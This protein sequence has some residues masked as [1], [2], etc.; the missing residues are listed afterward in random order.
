MFKYKFLTLHEA[1]KGTGAG[2]NAGGEQAGTHE[3]DKEKQT[4]P[5]GAEKTFT[6]AELEA[7]IKDRLDR[8]KRKAEEKADQARKDAERKA[9]EEQGEYKKMYEAL[10][11]DLR[12]KERQVLEVKKHTLLLKAGYTEE[13]AERYVKYLTADSEEGLATDLETLKADIPPTA[14]GVDPSTQGNGQRR[15]HKENSPYDY[16]KSVLERLKKSGRLR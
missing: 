3:A 1:D 14:K 12:E 2:G 4:T 16:G 8:E 9:L 13:Q 11:D 10:Q 5:E 6:Q 7:I 15:E